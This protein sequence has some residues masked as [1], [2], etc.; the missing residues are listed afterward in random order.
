MTHSPAT[1]IPPSATRSVWVFRLEMG[2]EL[3]EALVDDG[4]LAQGLGVAQ[5]DRSK[6]EL[7]EGEDFLEYGFLRYL[8]EGHGFPLDALIPDAEALNALRGPI[9]LVFRAALPAG[10]GTLAPEPR[11]HLIGRYDEAA[12]DAPQ[13][14][15]PL[16][17]TEGELGPAPRKKPSEAA[18]SGRVAT[19][20]LGFLVLFCVAFVWIAS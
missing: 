2:Q 14:M 5:I 17:A 10:L 16:H 12:L 18:M 9:L 1:S 15:P 13:A 8:H 3:A 20:V 19:L 4:P 6:V 11:L 7:V